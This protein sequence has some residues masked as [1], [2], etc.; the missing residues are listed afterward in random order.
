MVEP[1]V[2]LNPDRSQASLPFV[3]V[4][5]LCEKFSNEWEPDQRAN[6][7]SYL[8]R[9]ADDA[10]ES[11]LINLLQYEIQRRRQEGERPRAEEYIQHFPQFASLVRK[12]FLESTSAGSSVDSKT[13]AT[14][15]LDSKPLAASRLGDYR[16]LRELGRGGMGVV[17][18]AIH[19]T[20]G[21]RVALKLLP[22]VDGSRLYRFKREFR[23]AADIGHPNL[24][25]LHSLEADG[26]QWFFTMELVEG[27]DFLEYVRPRGQLNEHRLRSALSQL[28]MGVM[29]LHRNHIIHRD[30]KPSNV[31]VTHDGHVILLDF[32]LVLEL[33]VANIS[34]SADGIAG[35]PGYMAPEQA[36]G[37]PVSASGD[38]YAVGVMLYEALS[39]CRPFS[40][41]LWEILQ[42]KQTL[43][44]PPLPE[45]PVIPGDLAA[46]CTRLLARDP[47]QRPD[48]LEIAKMVSA[49]LQLDSAAT[50]LSSGH[51]LVG[52]ELHLG[53]LKEA[54]GTL[55]RQR[56]PQ[57]VF[58]SGR[59]GEGK[60][61]LGEQFLGQLRQDRQAVVMAGRCYDRE[62][63]PFKAL[64]SLIDALASYLRALPET[65]AA[66]LMPDD[67]GVLARVFPVLQR[68]E[69]VAMAAAVPFATLDDQQVR[70]RAFGALRSL[71]GRM[72]KRSPIVWFIDDLQ[73][74]DSDSA[75]AL[76]ET[77]RPPEAPQVLL[78]CTYRSDETEGSAFLKMWKELQRKHNVRFAE[79]E[80][81]LAP[82][83]VEECI[84]LV[85]GLLGKDND[86]IR[87]RAIEFARETRGNPFLLIELVGCFDP[88]TDSFEPMP[89]HEVLD[90][91]LGRLP[92]EAGHLLDV[93]AV[94][95]QALSLAEASRTAGHALP[96]MATISRMRNERLVRLVGPEESPLVDTYHDRV[97]ETILGRMEEGTSRTIH[98]TLAEVIEQDMGGVTTDLIAALESEEKRDEYK[99]IPRVYDLAY[100]YD[101]AGEQRKAWIYALLAAEQARRQSALEVATQ[102]YAIAKRNAGETNNAV[103]Y[104]IAEGYGEAL[105][106][107]GRYDEATR[108][109][110]GAIDL[111]E[112]PEK[113]ARIEALQGELAFKQGSVDTSIAYYEEGL[114]RLG[115]W[116]PKTL[117]GVVCGIAREALIQSANSLVP[118]LLHKKAASSQLDLTI[119]LFNRISHP[120]IFQNT[121][122]MMW[123]HL[124]AINRAE[125]RPSSRDLSYAYAMHAGVTAMLGW[126][127]RGSRYGDRSL[128]MARELNDLLGYGISS[129][130][131]GI[132]LYPAAHYEEGL[133]R[134]TEAVDAFAKAGDLYELNLANFHLGCC[135]FGLGNLAEAVATARST[136]ASST[137]IGDS[138]TLCSSYLWAR[139][140]R[141][142][143]PFAE[144]QSC[145]PCRPD[146]VMS[147]VHGIMAEGH[148]HTHHGRTAEALQ[149]FERAAQSVWKSLCV[150]SHMIVVMPELA[151][152]LR[153]HA[154]AL[155]V[156]DATQAEQLRRR[157]Y[158]VAKWAT[159]LTWLF[160]AAYPLALRERSLV[161]AACGNT[162]KALKYADKSCAVAKAQK[163]KYEHAQSLLVRGTIARQ[164]GL[165]EAD[166]Q[167]RVAEESLDAIEKALGAGGALANPP[168]SRPAGQAPGGSA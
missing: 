65:A 136:F 143:I 27:V 127:A 165:P 126:N 75:E 159:R 77:L 42:A 125:L 37:L 157:A 20:R 28:A 84:E 40:G 14:A 89:L 3:Q 79:R 93:V 52:R 112:A 98:R 122:K 12:V 92:E 151:G 67:I 156:K 70:Q 34:R 74:G 19:V 135:H 53:A 144:L 38:W 120:Y 124:S 63:V 134:F 129:N 102:Q 73:W 17:Y 16:L 99:A 91:K 58:I 30:L 29:A 118:S 62:S 160:P 9:V 60:T 57:T 95:G 44:A 48:A 168:S 150:N 86:V 107:L 31:M 43:D 115:N 152:A 7:P 121:L 139:A 146:D 163:A 167:I 104:R 82:L 18:E 41:S 36:A 123:A 23:S 47:R 2:D 15:S 161:L 6:I 87:S 21:D 59:S 64:D 148:W 26:A 8:V 145:Y 131:T 155:Q 11:L 117:P 116:V 140:T 113:R 71:V 119:R 83:T 149:T 4:I 72:S 22:Q 90:R 88:D 166:E 24:I 141:G 78:L 61:A 97:R 132:G 128:E 68:V 103:R 33:E 154:D 51:G 50:P 110:E 96:P 81:K 153:R 39:G 69:V 133:A 158:R 114:R 94:S 55:Q 142:N 46:L 49:G 106:L 100:H 138:R 80:V 111:L 164:L 85:I 25:G 10:K 108:E 66:L 1:T 13:G 76:F 130:Y 56:A 5:S 54:Y 45:S 101:A 105:M 137:R 109:L 32:G 147:T 162:R 35:T